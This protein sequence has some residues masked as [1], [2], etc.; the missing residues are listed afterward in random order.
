[1]Y[2]FKKDN[3]AEI[4]RKFSKYFEIILQKLRKIFSEI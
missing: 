3:F 2:F 4:L 1:M